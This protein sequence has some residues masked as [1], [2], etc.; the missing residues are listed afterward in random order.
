MQL[1]SGEED[2][3]SDED[4][5]PDALENG[6]LGTL[7]NNRDSDGDGWDDYFEVT[8]GGYLNANEK[9]LIDLLLEAANPPTV[10]WW[11][12]PGLVYRLGYYRQAENPDAYSEVWSGAATETNLEVDVEDVAVDPKGFFRVWV[13]T[14]SP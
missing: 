10:S 4:G 5:I 7:P 6:P 13:A 11:T 1:I 2:V 3:D 12:I 8:H 9:N 14:N